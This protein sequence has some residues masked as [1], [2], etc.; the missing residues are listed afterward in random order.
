MSL[1]EEIVN[2]IA[3]CDPWE[4][5]MDYDDRNKAANRIIRI[6]EKRIDENIKKAKNNAK[7]DGV[8][9]QG[10]NV[11]SSGEPDRYFILGLEKVKE[12]LNKE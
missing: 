5:H 3:D 12:M 9:Y 7:S 1:R 4:G 2:I 8:M 11:T 6:I 10:D